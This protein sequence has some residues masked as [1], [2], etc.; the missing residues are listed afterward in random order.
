MRKVDSNDIYVPEIIK[1]KPK[2]LTV[3]I[4]YVLLDRIYNLLIFK[5]NIKFEI[6]KFIIGK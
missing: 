2:V 4:K 6:S 3:K 5:L 1:K